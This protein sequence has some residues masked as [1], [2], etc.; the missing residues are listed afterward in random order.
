[1]LNALTYKVFSD[2]LGNKTRSLLIILSITVGLFAVGMIMSSQSILTAEVKESYA[3]INPSSGT[4]RTVETFDD[5]FID[6][7]RHEKGVADADAR[8]I[9]TGRFEFSPGVWR[10]IRI[11]AVDDY[12][13]MRVNKIFPVSGAWPPGKKEILLERSGVEFAGK[14]P[15]DM[16]TVTMPDDKVVHLY[17]AGI[18]HDM[19]QLPAAFDGFPYAYVSMDTMKYLGETDGYNELAV[20]PNPELDKRAAE[21]VTGRMKDKLE[22]SGYTI[23]LSMGA[24]PG[25]LPLED[26][27]QAILL[28]LGLLGFLSLFLSVFLIVNTI[29][30]LVIQQ[31]EQIGV[32]KAVGGR[33]YQIMG[34]YLCL[35]LCYGIIALIIAIP[36]GAVGAQFLSN[37]LAQF[38]NFEIRNTQT[39][40]SVIIVQVVIGLFGP[41]LAAFFPLVTN[42][43]G[44]AA[45]AMRTYIKAGAEK[46]INLLT[47]LSTAVNLWFSKVID[48]RPTLMSLRN[49][50]RSK[51]RLVLT[52]LTLTLAG[53]IF[54]SV[55]SVRS[56]LLGALEDMLSFYGFDVQINFSKE[57]RVETIKNELIQMPDVKD[58]DVMLNLPARYLRPDGSESKSIYLFAPPIGSPL[59]RPPGMMQGRWLDPQDEYAVVID[60]VMVKDENN[61]RVGDEIKLKINGRKHIWRVVGISVG[62]MMP[63]MYANYPVMA[64]EVG[65]VGNTS[66]ALVLG[67]Y[68]SHADQVR[69]ANRLETLMKKRGYRI[70]SIM[71]VGDEREELTMNF[72]IL[73]Y[74]LLIMAILLAIVGGMGLMGTM[75][76]NVI[77]RTR[78]IGVLRAIG[79]SNRS[80]ALVFMR[81][82]VLIGLASWVLGTLASFPFSRVL[83]SLIGDIMLGAPMS[84]LF[85]YDGI[86]LWLVLVVVIS[87]MASFLPARSASRLT[88]RE[89][90]AYE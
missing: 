36:L 13:E 64:A 4:I 43:R 33:T 2:L 83:C 40:L 21:E 62:V 1:M 44:W 41:C 80:V 34:M 10:D 75:S 61:I 32:M 66:A 55:F 69:L 18:A 71:V 60:S 42:L 51:G 50:I 14:K 29:S 20:V 11:F 49:T 53:A 12:N 74:L 3:R 46:K 87:L 38:F 88:V 76:I 84:V 7:V 52:L 22:K 37:F 25:A 15:G 23:M 31:I 79:A 45:E 73:I 63:M 24:E 17:V 48:A 47:R 78:E 68:H 72:S 28:I 26:I 65:S 58:V 9:V 59:I 85:S 89:V 54:I 86:W 56:S 57:Y 90:L 81:E 5:D 27:M 70:S 67:N 39:P 16:L 82:G 6:S 8:H 35:V 30:A 19:I 77:E